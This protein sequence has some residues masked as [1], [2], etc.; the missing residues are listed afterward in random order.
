MIRLTSLAPK[1]SLYI[2]F[3]ADVFPVQMAE[4]GDTVSFRFHPKNH[5]VTQ[6]SF[7]APC[8][9]LYGGIDTGLCVFIHPSKYISHRVFSDVSSYRIASLLQWVLLTTTS[10]LGNSLF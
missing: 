10:P 9:S 5:T 1:Q 3:C 6:S 4:P 8:T 7:G 2:D